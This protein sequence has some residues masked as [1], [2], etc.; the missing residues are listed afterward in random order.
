MH[1]SL[2]DDELRAFRTSVQKFIQAEL[3][4]HHERWRESGVV[5]RA[6]FQKAGAHGLLCTT[7]ST[8]YGGAGLGFRYAA[9]VI[10]ELSK[11]HC[12]DV[13]FSLHSDIVAPYIEHNGTEEQK[14]KWLPGMAAGTLIGAIAMTEPGTGWDL[15]PI[16]TKAV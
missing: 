15:Q 13:F 12:G 1:D 5:D 2:H 3:L 16:Q 8:D 11:S 4:P 6:V 9:V 7:Q 14:Q 10:E